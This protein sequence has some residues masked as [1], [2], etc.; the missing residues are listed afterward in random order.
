MNTNSFVNKIY[1][2]KKREKKTQL[3]RAEI[4]K[5]I[6]LLK[7]EDI[8]LRFFVG[9]LLISQRAKSIPSLVEGAHNIN[10]EIRRSSIYLLGKL[11]KKGKKFSKPTIIKILH[12]ALLDSDPKVRKNS[13][14]ILGTL[15]LK[16]SAEKLIAALKAETV[17]WIRP[18]MI[19]S[20]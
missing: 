4:D 2:L 15:S 16:E 18:S 3:S 10:P 14:V 9:D 1:A 6:N 19:L 13:V 5:A 11:F 7:T 17:E 12:N 8:K 20:L